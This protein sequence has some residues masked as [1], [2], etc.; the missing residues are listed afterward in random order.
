MKLLDRYIISSILR[1]SLSTLAICTLLVVAVEMFSSMNDYVTNALPF[2]EILYLA[3]LG[4]PEYL[5]MC[6]SVSFLFGTTFFL[7]QLES[8][9]EMIMLLNAGL[10][11]RRICSPALVMT[12]V[13]TIL[14]FIFSQTIM[15]DAGIEHDRLSVEHFGQTSTQDSSNISVSSLDGSCIVDSS[16]FSQEL[17]RLFDVTF[18]SKDDAAPFSELV[19]RSPIP[20]VA[21]IHFDWRMALAAL[22][23]GAPKIRINPGNI[24]SDDHVKAVADECRRRNIP[25]R[26]GVNSGSLE[27]EILA[28][29]GSP[30][31]EALCESALYHASLLEKFDFDDIVLS[32]K[33]SSVDTMICAYELASEACQY[34]LHL[35]VTEAGTARHTTQP[36][37]P[38]ALSWMP[39]STR[40]SSYLDLR[41]VAI[42][43]PLMNM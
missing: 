19:R 13:V 34:P 6:A 16:Y 17:G 24:G 40:H 25:I 33:S 2:Q 8:N 7:S 21:D 15:I 4:L 12:L 10:G 20:L 3:V 1:V 29:Y 35:G 41:P 36:F 22:E 28:K 30:T 14:A 23:A 27:K 43:S 18:V 37:L 38:E 42:S 11:Y 5:M 31:P 39:S 26:I 9:N 32:I